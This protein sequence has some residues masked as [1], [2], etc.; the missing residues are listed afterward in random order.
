MVRSKVEDFARLRHAQESARRKQRCTEEGDKF[1]K[2]KLHESAGTSPTA[3]RKSLKGDANHTAS[4]KFT[5]EVVDLSDDLECSDA[6]REH[7]VVSKSSKG[8]VKLAASRK[9]NNEVVV[10]LE[11]I[12]YSEATK[13]TG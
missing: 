9:S 6:T 11:E 3:S 2:L 1:Q 5:K 13:N 12:K 10:T 4:R 8:D 7:Q